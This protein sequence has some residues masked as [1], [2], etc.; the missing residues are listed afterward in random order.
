MIFC[1]LIVV[2]VV[3]QEGIVKV[4]FLHI[5]ISNRQYHNIRVRINGIFKSIPHNRIVS[6]CPATLSAGENHGDI[7]KMLIRW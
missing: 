6:D 4:R 1:A 7:Y 5:K 3:A 2:V